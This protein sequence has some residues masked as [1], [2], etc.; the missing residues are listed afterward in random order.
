VDSWVPE[1]PENFLASLASISLSYKDSA[2]WSEL[3]VI[4]HRPLTG[5]DAVLLRHQCSSDKA[6]HFIHEAAHRF[7]FLA[8]HRLNLN[9]HDES[10]VTVLN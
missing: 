4:D 3:V 8:C 7:R 6:D 1:K 10:E 5:L 9:Y 2:P